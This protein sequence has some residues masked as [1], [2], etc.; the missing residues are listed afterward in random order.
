M[1]LFVFLWGMVSLA[2][3]EVIYQYV[4]SFEERAT[5]SRFKF[6]NTISSIW[7]VGL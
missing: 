7:Q 1:C 2:G 5:L 3:F 6:V 4:S